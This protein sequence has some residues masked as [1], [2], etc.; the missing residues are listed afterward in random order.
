[1]RLALLTLLALFLLAACGSDDAGE[2]AATTPP[3]TA[4]TEPADTG[5]AGTAAAIPDLVYVTEIDATKEGALV[6]SME[7]YE[8]NVIF[9][10][11]SVASSNLGEAPEVELSDLGC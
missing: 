11:T 2:P 5:A 6:A 9:G 10:V 3:P 8:G 4:A 7:R 1:M